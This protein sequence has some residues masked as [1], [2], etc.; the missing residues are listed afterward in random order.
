MVVEH[1]HELEE[2]KGTWE[3]PYH[4]VDSGLPNVYLVGIKYKICKTCGRQAAEIPAIKKLMQAIA[5]AIVESEAQ[6][7][8]P[9]IR[10]L[11]KRLGIKSSSFARV[12]GVSP[13]QVSR[14]ENENSGHEQSADKLIRVFYALVSGDRKLRPVVDEESI[15]H[16]LSMLHGQGQTPQ[17]RAK[18]RNNEWNVEPVPA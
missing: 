1:N 13:E 9:E 15:E 14:W 16:F 7:T 17:I 5:R 6:L 18:L 2:R 12:I 8:G 3:A 11:R 10:F 4:F